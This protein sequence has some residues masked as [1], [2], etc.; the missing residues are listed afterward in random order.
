MK[1]KLPTL[2]IMMHDSC[3]LETKEKTFLLIW[4]QG[5]SSS[6]NY[7]VTEIVKLF[8]KIGLSFQFSWNMASAYI[9]SLH[10]A[11]ISWIAYK[12]YFIA[13]SKTLYLMKGLYNFVN[14]A[15]TNVLLWV[16]RILRAFFVRLMS[17]IT[18]LLSPRINLKTFL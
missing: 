4:F 11:I 3:P 17:T 10:Y 6:L 14:L 9:L 15:N 13:T 2:E 8:Q 1:I 5:R 16:M 7:K 18:H 12:K